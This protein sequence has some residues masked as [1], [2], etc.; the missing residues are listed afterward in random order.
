MKRQLSASVL[1]SFLLITGAK[2]ASAQIIWEQDYRGKKISCGVSG[3]SGFGD[4][5]GFEYDD[6]DFVGKILSYEELP[7]DEFHLT[8]SPTEIFKGDLPGI[9]EMSTRSGA[10]MSKFRIGD[11]WLFA[12]KRDKQSGELLLWFGSSGGPLPES[13][14]Q[15]DKFRRLARMKDAGLIVGELTDD[16]LLGDRRSG[17]KVVVR[18]LAD[19]D[20]HVAI[21]DT[22]GH[23]EF[24]PL[25]VGRYFIDPNTLSGLWSGDGGETKV[26]AHEC[27]DYHISMHVDG[28]IRGSV[29]LPNGDTSRTWNVDAQP[30]DAPDTSAASAFTDSDGHFELHGLKSGQYVIGIEVAGVSSR[31]DLNFGVY[32]PGVR[33]RIEAQVVRLGTGEKRENV[34]IHLP[35]ESLK[36]LEP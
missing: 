12:A 5:C 3:L 30:L 36:A 15:V 24:P 4:S 17:Q 1:T 23:F 20:E 2:L 33:N 16:S 8:V 34:D 29:I 22:D 14:K 18:S 19:G 25:P 10:C 27:R 28:S 7:A 11:E 6:A 9:V 35:A 32:A 13:A 26:E 31:Y 21:T